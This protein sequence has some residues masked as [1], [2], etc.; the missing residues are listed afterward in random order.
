MLR[1][2][3]EELAKAKELGIDPTGMT[4]PYLREAI[5]K[6]SRYGKLPSLRDNK[7][8]ERLIFVADALDVP[9]NPGDGVRTVMDRI[10][11]YVSGVFEEKGIS[12]NTRISFTDGY[13]PYTGRE[14]IVNDTDI[15]WFEFSGQIRLRVEDGTL[16]PIGAY[17][18]VL[19]AFV[20]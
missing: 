5:Q 7:K 16:R 19:H 13:P 8:Y 6:A 11:E 17:L 3:E 1:P 10:E 20:L 15:S 2:T 12:P 14:L 18:V 9:V 4:G